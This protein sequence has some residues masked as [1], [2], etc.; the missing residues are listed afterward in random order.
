MEQVRADQQVDPVA[1]AMT[2]LAAV[3]QLAPLG[4]FIGGV[5]LKRILGGIIA[6][7]EELFNQVDWEEPA[8]LN[9][10]TEDSSISDIE[11]RDLKM[12]NVKLTP[13]QN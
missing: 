8:H 13:E 2:F 5:L 3:Q 10:P 12:E 6:D 7:V 9:T 4:R 11:P 1:V